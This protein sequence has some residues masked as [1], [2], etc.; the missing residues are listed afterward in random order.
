MAKQ[1][2]KGRVLEMSGK[3]VFEDNPFM[4]DFIDWMNSPRGQL[5][6]DVREKVW[7][8]LEKADVD[9]RNQ[10]II[11]RK[12]QRLSISESVKRICSKHPKLPE[13]L[14]ETHLIAWLQMEFAPDHYSQTQLDELDLLTEKWIND[15]INNQ[16][17]NK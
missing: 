4:D 15:H 6:D 11:W 8:M 12:G 9:A 7:G 1:N 14:I 3:S 13:D 10:K 17:E 16:Q 5:S 2:K